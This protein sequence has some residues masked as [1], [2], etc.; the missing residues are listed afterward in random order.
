MRSA[1][2]PEHEPAGVGDDGDPDRV[3]GEQRH[4]GQNL[5]HR[6]PNANS[7]V[8]EARTFV[9]VRLNTRG[10]PN[11]ARPNSSPSNG[12]A[13]PATSMSAL[14]PSACELDLS[15]SARSITCR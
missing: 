9:I 8:S 1:P 14:P 15:A 10:P 6:A 4:V 3:L 7:G 13:S 12:G 11:I 5:A 2:S